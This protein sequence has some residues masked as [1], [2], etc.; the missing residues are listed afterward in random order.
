MK[1]LN[2]L[3]EVNLRERWKFLEDFEREIRILL[4][5]VWFYDKVN[6]IK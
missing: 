6:K 1:F 4:D 3:F 2:D 5:I